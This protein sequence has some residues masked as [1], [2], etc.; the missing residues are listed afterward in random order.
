MKTTFLRNIL[1]PAAL[2]ILFFSAAAQNNT[3]AKYR[4]TAYKNGDTTVT[5]QSNTAEV[6]PPAVLFVPNAFTPN[7]DGLNDAFGA[8]GNGIIE[9]N[10][11]IFNRWGE[12]V[13]ES[14]DING[15]WDGTYKGE[16]AEMGAYAYN[17][18]AYGAKTNRI[19]KSGSVTLLN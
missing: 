5:S 3:P 13:F 4:V 14:N 11:Q 7:G 19:S 15:Q 18:T 2:I 9:Y 1:P 10:I 8:K 17:I 16:K 6:A 12:L